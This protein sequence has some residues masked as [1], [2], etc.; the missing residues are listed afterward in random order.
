[1]MDYFIAN[2]SSFLMYDNE[3]KT[4]AEKK[5]QITIYS[6]KKMVHKFHVFNLIEKKNKMNKTEFY[7]HT[8]I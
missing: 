6:I 8:H 4:M 2:L 5:P 3:N 1:M 7:T